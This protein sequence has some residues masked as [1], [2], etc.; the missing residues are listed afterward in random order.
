MMGDDVCR[1]LAARYHVVP[2]FFLLSPTSQGPSISCP[3]GPATSPC[4]HPHILCSRLFPAA[5]NANVRACTLTYFAHYAF[6][7]GCRPLIHRRVKCPVDVAHWPAPIR[8]FRRSFQL[9]HHLQPDATTCR[10]FSTLYSLIPTLPYCNQFAP[11]RALFVFHSF[12]PPTTTSLYTVALRW[13]VYRI[14]EKSPVQQS[15]Q[16]PPFRDP[17]HIPADNQKC[18]FPSSLHAEL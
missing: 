1:A 8:L 11:A 7:S 17:K 3:F 18:A 13:K 6:C 15:R 16:G 5:A 9:F 12:L 10:I 4:E 14:V 2:Y